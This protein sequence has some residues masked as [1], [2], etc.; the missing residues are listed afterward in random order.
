MRLFGGIFWHRQ[1]RETARIRGRQG[2]RNIRTRIPVQKE[3][4]KCQSL[5]LRHR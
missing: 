4:T 1:D 3:A 5:D 2:N